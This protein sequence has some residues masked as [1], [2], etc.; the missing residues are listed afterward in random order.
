MDTSADHRRR[1]DAGRIRRPRGA[2]GRPARRRAGVPGRVSPGGAGSAGG[3]AGARRAVRGRMDGAGAAPE[4]PGRGQPA[5]TMDEGGPRARSRTSRR[6]GRPTW[7]PAW[8][9]SALPF[10]RDV[11]KL[12]E[13]GLTESLETGYRLSPR[14]RALLERLRP[15]QLNAR[16]PILCRPGRA[17]P[18]SRLRISLPPWTRPL[19]ERWKRITAAARR[20]NKDDRLVEGRAQGPGGCCPGTIASGIPS[21]RPARSRRSSPGG[22]S[23]S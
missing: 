13:L 6:H 16:E 3:A 2:A 22:S 18:A 4:A 19:T 10:K 11:R 23:A 1:R 8:G 14:G 21:R 7:P 9:V 15:E 20:F 12:K 5:R 17:I